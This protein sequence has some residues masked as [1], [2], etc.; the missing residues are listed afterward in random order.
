MNTRPTVNPRAVVSALLT[1]DVV[2][3]KFEL[4]R[5]AA[6]FIEAGLVDKAILVFAPLLIGGRDAV[7]LFTGRG[8][9]RLADAPRL[10]RVSSFRLG[11]DLFMEGYF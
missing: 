7:S 5:T 1:T 9:R 11:G 4:G 8:S 6:G 10:S 3:W 2:T